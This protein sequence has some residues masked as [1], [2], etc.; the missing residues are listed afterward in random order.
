[1]NFYTIFVT[2]FLL[3]DGIG[4]IP[5]FLSILGKYSNADQRKIIIREMAFAFLILSLFFFCG[6]AILDLMNI[7]VSAV[8]ISGG[9][10]LFLMAIK[11]IYPSDKSTSQEDESDPFIVPLAIPLIAGPSNIAMVMIIAQHNSIGIWLSWLSITLACFATLL[12]LLIAP[13]LKRI[14]GK[15]GM[16]AIERLMGMILTI[17]GIQMVITGVLQVIK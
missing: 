8:Q 5:I 6:K 4:N 10:I 13:F 3:M 15:R 2:I 1:M 7:S 11:M 17:I 14:L 12:I 16:R 9:V